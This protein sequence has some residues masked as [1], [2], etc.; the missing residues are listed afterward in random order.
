MPDA[1]AIAE[2]A[3]ELAF[4]LGAKFPGLSA[5]DIEISPEQDAEFIRAD[6]EGWTA[7]FPQSEA[8]ASQLSI[9]ST[10]MPHL[11]GFLSPAVPVWEQSS[12]SR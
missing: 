2:R 10:V 11:R 12:G 8:A 3:T 7:L 4:A 5:D 1:P 6:W 9:M